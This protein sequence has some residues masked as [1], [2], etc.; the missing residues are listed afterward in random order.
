MGYDIQLYVEKRV[1]GQW[2]PADKWVPNTDTYD[3]SPAVIVEDDDLFY[4]KR[5]AVVFSILG[6]PWCTFAPISSPRGL[7]DD[8]TPEVWAMSDFYDGLGGCYHSWLT[9]RELL[10]YDWEACAAETRSFYPD[11]LTALQ[12]IGCADDVRIVFWFSY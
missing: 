9:L 3:G 8:V 4:A 5:S 10:A 11:R 6:G 7:P 2:V 1:Q 12:Q